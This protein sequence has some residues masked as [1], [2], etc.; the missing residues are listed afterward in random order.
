VGTTI[1]PTNNNAGAYYFQATIVGTTAS[2][3]NVNFPAPAGSWP[4]TIGSTQVDGGVT[5]KN[6]GQSLSTSPKT[7]IFSPG[8]YYL[9]TGGLDLGSNS[10]VRMSTVSGDGNEGVT[11]YFSTSATVAVNA[12]T[13]SATACTA[14]VA[15][16]GTPNNCLV[17]YKPNG[18]TLLGVASRQLQCSAAG[19]P[20]L[21]SQVP[22][23][24]NGNILFG[25]CAGTYGDTLGQNRGFL[26]FQNRSVSA[27][28]SWG[29]GG[30]FLLSGFMYFHSSSTGATCGTNTTCL[31]M[32][33]GSGAGAYT[34]GNIVADKVA[35]SGNSSINMILN[36]ASTFQILKPQLLR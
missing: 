2:T 8:L 11:F 35:L 16:S 27:N 17:S 23:T 32:T 20:A 26:F 14:A 34:L 19:S 1:K 9:G 33:G 21:P 7:A 10:N 15:G 25:P 36:P 18:S 5:W 31:S 29:G 22:A 24:I 6:V 13:G 30:E 4:Q 28:P 3:T 12:N